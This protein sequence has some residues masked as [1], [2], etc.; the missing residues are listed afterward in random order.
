MP[1]NSTQSEQVKRAQRELAFKMRLEP[2]LKRDLRKLFRLIARDLRTT[3]IETGG[4]IDASTYTNNFTRILDIHYRRVQRAFTG[5]ILNFLNE[6]T[7]NLNESIIRDLT[8]IAQLDEITLRQLVN[9]LNETVKFGLTQERI[10]NVSEST[11]RIVRTTQNQLLNSV[12]KNTILLREELGREPTNR[13][14]SIASSEDF[15]RRSLNRVDTIAATETQ[16]AAEGTKQVERDAFFNVRNS[17]QATRLGLRPLDQ[18]DVWVTQGDS[19][20]RDGSLGPF[21]H[22]SADGQI[23]RQ[24]VFRVSGQLL[25]YPSDTSLGA[26]AGNIIK[27]RCSAITVIE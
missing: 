12:T 10:I 24:G 21:N 8:Q 1:I 7:N 9:N 25:R 19:I 26:S 14:L 16:K 6:N 20:V 23:R 22:L 18:K 15:L 3:I 5:E 13:E 4:V 27:C 17:A 11:V 2:A